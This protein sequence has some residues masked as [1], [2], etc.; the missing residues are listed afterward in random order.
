MKEKVAPRITLGSPVRAE[1]TA[2]MT[3][4]Q[5]ESQ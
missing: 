4:E 2:Q 1:I 5:L 3:K